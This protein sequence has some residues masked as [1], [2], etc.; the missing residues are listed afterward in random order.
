MF[1]QVSRPLKVGDTLPA[2]LTFASG[3][4]VKAAFVVGL[5][6]PTAPAAKR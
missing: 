4:K 2:T 6:P 3:A 5:A 1:L